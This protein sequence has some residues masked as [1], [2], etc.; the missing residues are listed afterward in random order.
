MNKGRESRYAP[1]HRLDPDAQRLMQAAQVQADARGGTFV[2]SGFL[3]QEAAKSHDRIRA[4]LLPALV[5][6]IS[7]LMVIVDEEWRSRPSATQDDPPTLVS[8]AVA[9]EWLRHPDEPVTVNR[10][11]GAILQFEGAMASRIVRRLGMEPVE[12]ARQLVE[13]G[14]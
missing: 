1:F 8:E 7:S 13:D 3:L 4:R 14:S 9:S 5:A 11:M 2:V 10:L 12:L 6:D